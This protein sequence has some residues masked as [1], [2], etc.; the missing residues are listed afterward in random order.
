MNAYISAKHLR[1]LGARVSAA[2]DKIRVEALVGVLTPELK[3]ALEENKPALL[4][5]LRPFSPPVIP[6]PHGEAPLNYR[7][8]PFSGEW[9]YEPD[10]WT[11]L[12]PA[13]DRCEERFP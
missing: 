10:W 11:Y 8:A 9:V 13:R 5:L 2:R 12:A 4:E 3:A 6:G 1:S 7:F